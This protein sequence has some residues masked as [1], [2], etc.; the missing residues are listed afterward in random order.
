MCVEVTYP[1][2]EATTGGMLTLLNNVG[3]LIFV[4][5]GKQSRKYPFNTI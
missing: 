3:T 4:F 5:A 2:P 1:V